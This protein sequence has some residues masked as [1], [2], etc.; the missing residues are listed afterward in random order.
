LPSVEDIVDETAPAWRSWDL[1]RD[2]AT[3]LAAEIYPSHP[4]RG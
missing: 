2:E 3:A 1:N 4:R